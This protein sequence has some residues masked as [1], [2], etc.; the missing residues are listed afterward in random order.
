M[1]KNEGAKKCR[2]L[3][4]KYKKTCDDVDVYHQCPIKPI[5]DMS[6]EELDEYIKETTKKF[7]KTKK[8]YDERYKHRLKCITEEEY[9]EGHDKQFTLLK[10]QLNL[11]EDIIE[12]GYERL[13]KELEKLNKIQENIHKLDMKSK[14]I[15]ENK[16]HI[17]EKNVSDTSPIIKQKSVPSKKKSLS[18]P[19]TSKKSI[20]TI[21]NELGDQ[22]KVYN[23]KHIS[24]IKHIKSKMDNIHDIFVNR[25]RTVFSH[26]DTIDKT[27]IYI[28]LNNLIDLFVYN[29]ILVYDIL[30]SVDPSLVINIKKNF[31][32]QP[33]KIYDVLDQNLN[34]KQLE[35]LLNR[36]SSFNNFSQYF[37]YIDRF[38][39]DS[40]LK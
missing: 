23:D 36:L 40:L 18:T 30:K 38:I 4:K 13:E 11:C 22:N 6:I 27:S 37:D 3:Y 8:C 7:N 24:L 12:K 9:D 5:M 31:T 21:F 35:L 1:S 33:V 15:H 10:Q 39:A 20:H 34:N 25:Y 32:S 19:R 14:N 26:L 29:D 16:K 2:S 28:E 17:S